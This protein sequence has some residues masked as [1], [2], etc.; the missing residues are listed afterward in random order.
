[1]IVSHYHHSTTATARL[2]AICDDQNI[3]T[4]DLIIDNV[5]RWNSS[6]NMMERNYLLRTPLTMDLED[7][8]ETHLILTSED[9]KVTKEAIAVLLP[10]KHACIYLR[11]QY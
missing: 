11:L 2:R 8:N 1:M 9:W 5:T 4:N 3:S 10:F 6:F 7:N